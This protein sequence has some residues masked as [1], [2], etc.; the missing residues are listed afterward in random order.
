MTFEF[1]CKGCDE[2]HQG[3]PSLDAAAPLSYYAVPE[4]EREARCQLDSDAC[5]IDESMY[6]VRGCLEIPVHGSL[7]RFR[8]AFGC[9]SA[10]R[11]FANGSRVT[12]QR[13]AR[14][15]GLSLDG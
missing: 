8:G 9:R 15:S 11:V 5:I 3:M 4:D 7:N 1:L 6:F 13:R 10:S 14:I 2:I 12:S